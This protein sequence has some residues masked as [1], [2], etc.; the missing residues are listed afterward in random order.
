LNSTLIKEKRLKIFL[1]FSYP[2]G[3]WLD[4]SANYISDEKHKSYFKKHNSR[5]SFFHQLDSTKYT[6][7]CTWKGKASVLKKGPHYFLI[8]P[9]TNENIFELSALFTPKQTVLSVP[10]FSETKK[11]V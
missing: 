1:R 7:G 8:E 11:T 9:T 10:T 2:T 4:E 5:A 6:V 3:E